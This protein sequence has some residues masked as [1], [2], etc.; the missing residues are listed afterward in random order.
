MLPILLALMLPANFV[1]L[2]ATGPVIF[3]DQALAYVTLNGTRAAVELPLL[4]GVHRVSYGGLDHNVSFYGLECFTEGQF[5]CNVTAREPLELR[6]WLTCGG[7]D[8]GKLQLEPGEEVRLEA[9]GDCD[10]AKISIGD[11][12]Q[13]FNFT[14][15]YTNYI[16]FEGEHQ[17]TVRNGSRVVLQKYGRGYVG[18]PELDPGSYHVQAGPVEGKLRVKPVETVEL[19]YALS[20]VLVMAAVALLWMG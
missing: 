17:V 14:R 10:V 4:P 9:G 2:N 18:F 20:A 13:A 11:H 7:S 5:A 1:M 3:N 19:G 8:V 16:T 12:Y 15:V 6:Y